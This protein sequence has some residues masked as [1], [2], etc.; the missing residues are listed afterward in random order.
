MWVDGCRPTLREARPVSAWQLPVRS[1]TADDRIRLHALRLRVEGRGR[2]FCRHRVAAWTVCLRSGVDP[3]RQCPLRIATPDHPR[4]ARAVRLHRSCSSCR[5]RVACRIRRYAGHL[6][7]RPWRAS[8]K[9]RSSDDPIGIQ[10][11]PCRTSV[12]GFRYTPGM[13]RFIRML[14]LCLAALAIPLQGIAAIAM[15]LCP[16]AHSAAMLVASPD[17]SG[18]HM[19]GRH[20]SGS[21]AGDVRH[22]DGHGPASPS[23]DVPVT[24]DTD[25]AS[26]VGKNMVKCYGVGGTIASPCA[27]GLASRA[28]PASA[29]PL[30]P[31][32][33][34]YQ[35]VILDGL[36]R[37]PRQISA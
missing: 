21:H 25:H 12:S 10:R 36:E 15:P 19:A 1:R 23:A 20:A 17:A 5:W 28:Q 9:G 13:I 6:C 11:M 32:A 27:T 2:T 8:A 29:A 4:I 30:Q 18:A 35:G 7:W 31:A 34:I 33:Q 37:P 26:P 3:D 22:A 16:P 14:A 24:A